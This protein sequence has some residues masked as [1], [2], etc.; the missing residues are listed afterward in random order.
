MR[1]YAYKAQ[2]EEQDPWVD[3][4][5]RDAASGAVGGGARVVVLVVPVGDGVCVCREGGSMRVRGVGWGGSEAAPACRP[6]GPFCAV[7]AAFFHGASLTSHVP[8]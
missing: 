8:W 5:F 7:A 1:S 3:L 4:A 6:V 2:L